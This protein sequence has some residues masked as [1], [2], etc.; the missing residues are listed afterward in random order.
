MFVDKK[1]TRSDWFAIRN[2]IHRGVVSTGLV[3]CLLLRVWAVLG[4]VTWLV[5]VEARASHGGRSCRGTSSLSL[6]LG[7]RWAIAPLILRRWWSI[8]LG[9][10]CTEP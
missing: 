3:G 4:E 7:C 6:S 9:S 2:L 1:R 5:I 10:R 8:P